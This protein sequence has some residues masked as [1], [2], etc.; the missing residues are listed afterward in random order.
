M[1]GEHALSSYEYAGGGWFR[2]KGVPRG[3]PAPMLHGPE[4]LERAK[5]LEAVVGHSTENLSQGG[6]A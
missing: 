1:S 5:A 4:V 6:E 3:T 2:L